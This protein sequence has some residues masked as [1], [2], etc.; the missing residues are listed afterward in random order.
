MYTFA[1]AA[2]S[3]GATLILRARPAATMAAAMAALAKI[4]CS[5]LKICFW[6]GLCTQ[7]A[8]G[9][10]PACARGLHA[11]LGP[12]VHMC[13]RACMQH[14]APL[15]MCARACMQHLAPMCICARRPACSTWP[16]CACARGPACCWCVHVTCILPA[17]CSLQSL[18]AARQASRPH[19]MRSMPSMAK[20]RGR[21]TASTGWF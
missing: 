15:C 7:P 6:S 20:R 19:G 17:A 5:G 21:S 12:H 14:L 1:S 11:A 3:V 9:L 18:G 4:T 10:R 2:L 13:A 8:C 16:P